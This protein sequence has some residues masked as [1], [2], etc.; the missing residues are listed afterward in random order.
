MNRRDW[1]GI[2]GGAPEDFRRGLRAALDGLKEDENMGN[3]G[4]R[5]LAAVLIAAAVAILALTGGALA[6]RELGLFKLLTDMAMPIVPLPGAE[7]MVETELGSVENDL[8]RLTVEE[9]AYDGQGAL[10]QLRFA[11]KVDA[12][13]FA[14]TSDAL[15]AAWE[16]GTYLCEEDGAG[17]RYTLGRSD[18]RGEIACGAVVTLVSADGGEIYMDSWRGEE[19]EDG[20]IVL[21]AS[22][23][24]EQPL[25]ERVTLRVEPV[26]RLRVQWDAR[27]ADGAWIEAGW[28]A[29]E[30]HEL[31]AIEAPMRLSVA[32]RY[33]ELIPQNKLERVE[34]LRAGVCQ[35]PIRSYLTIEYSYEPLPEEDMGMSFRIYD[36]QG[37]EI[38][39][40]GGAGTERADG[41]RYWTFA[42]QSFGEI[43][44]A[45]EL[46]A[47]VIDGTPL[48]RIICAVREADAPTVTVPA[49][50]AEGAD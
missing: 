8:V 4:G 28:D 9:A 20:S 24:A 10:V 35:T 12:A 25:G 29:Y 7:E 43:P 32:K 50:G 36:A 48:G 1:Q 11:P 18:G 3:R 19:R 40:G 2:Y 49:A 21:L 14:L 34:V 33:L 31:A 39:T 47:K 41:K 30:S 23:M 44:E 5:R 46:E 16:N 15:D 27:G 22:G 37:S 38:S 42:L 26:V 6:A 17:A 13:Q 45:L